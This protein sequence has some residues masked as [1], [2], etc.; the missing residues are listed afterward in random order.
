ML[1]LATLGGRHVLQ[2][3]AC[4]DLHDQGGRGS[5]K[6]WFCSILFDRIGVGF[7]QAG[8]E[9]YPDRRRRCWHVGA[10]GSFRLVTCS[11]KLPPSGYAREGVGSSLAR[12]TVVP[13]WMQQLLLTRVATRK[14]EGLGCHYNDERD[15]T[16]HRLA[17]RTES[18]RPGRSGAAAP[19]FVGKRERAQL[20]LA[21]GPRC[22]RRACVASTLR[23]GRPHGLSSGLKAYPAPSCAWPQRHKGLAQRIESIDTG[24]GG[25]F[26]V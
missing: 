10:C 22:C 11:N 13:G 17:Q 3:G 24:A 21:L 18:C 26:E 9:L 8:V 4:P 15:P 6:A 5:T 19:V 1:D 7:G 20:A 16:S 14:L 23:Y 12:W 2:M 25:P